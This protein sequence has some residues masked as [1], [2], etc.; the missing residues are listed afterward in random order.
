M[1]QYMDGA[2]CRR[3]HPNS[4]DLRYKAASQRCAE[5]G[6][7]V[8]T[9]CEHCDGR[10]RGDYDAP[11]VLL[12]VSSYEPPDFCDLC[13]G[14]HP[15]ASRPARLYELE[16]ILDEQQLNPADRLSVHEQL[17]G[18]RSEDLSEAEQEER[19]SRLKKLAPGMVEAGGRIIESLV[20]TAIRTQLGI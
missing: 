12:S 7:T 2:V 14:P 9:T 20:S 3:G 15:W 6:A 4:S 10:L 19:W 5:C 8:L 13:G 16:N 1:G 17:E 11:G 18:L